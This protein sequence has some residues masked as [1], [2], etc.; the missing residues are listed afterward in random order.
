MKGKVV[1]LLGKKEKEHS[2]TYTIFHECKRFSNLGIIGGFPMGR[3]PDKVGKLAKMKPR[4][5]EEKRLNKSARK[6]KEILLW[7][8]KNKL[9]MR[10]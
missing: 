9:K 2:L 7:F 1:A 3:L 10:I 4:K 6:T 8:L 5:V